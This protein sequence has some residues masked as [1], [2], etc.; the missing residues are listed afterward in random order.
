MATNDSLS[1]GSKSPLKDFW[2]TNCTDDPE[3]AYEQYVSLYHSCFK[4]ATSPAPYGRA[5]SSY[6]H[7]EGI[8]ECRER[9]LT[10]KNSMIAE[11]A[12]QDRAD[13][14]LELG[15]RYVFSTMASQA[16]QTYSMHALA[17]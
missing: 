7:R 17:R 1:K 14:I 5:S 13:D 8:K 2:K 4:P 9:L 11:G 16:A 10:M 15:L 6:F 12:S 3:F